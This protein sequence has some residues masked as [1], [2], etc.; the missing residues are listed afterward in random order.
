MHAIIPA[1]ECSPSAHALHGVL[2]VSPVSAEEVP[3]GHGE[4]TVDEEAKLPAGQS[5]VHLEAPKKETL[6]LQ[7]LHS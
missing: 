5:T 1:V 7:T 4:H 6:S 3:A 2:A